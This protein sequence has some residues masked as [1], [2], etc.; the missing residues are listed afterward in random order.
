MRKFCLSETIFG[1]CV[2]RSGNGGLSW[3]YILLF[4]EHPSSNR[5]FLEMGSAVWLEKARGPLSW[6][7]SASSDGYGASR[8]PACSTEV[9]NSLKCRNQI[10]LA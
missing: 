4:V 2:L 9:G 5:S 8:R 6:A 1:T 10:Y 3:A 7:Y